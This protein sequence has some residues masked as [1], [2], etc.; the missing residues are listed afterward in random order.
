MLK[1]EKFLRFFSMLMSKFV[2]FL[3]RCRG[4]DEDGTK[5]NHET[6]KPAPTHRKTSLINLNLKF[7][8]N[9]DQRLKFREFSL[10]GPFQTP[11]SF[12][13][14]ELR[15]ENSWEGDKLIK[16]VFPLI[17][18]MF[19]VNFRWHFPTPSQHWL[20]HN[21]RTLMVLRISFRGAF[22]KK[23]WIRF[24]AFWCKVQ[25]RKNSWNYCNRNWSL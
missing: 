5:R 22:K 7:E 20:L 6:L 21:Q 23:I 10:N 15:F 14:H 16:S 17:F 3:A 1:V 13:Q 8:C 24:D 18:I 11:R 9:Q 4:D 12:Q 25:S 19:F 2:V